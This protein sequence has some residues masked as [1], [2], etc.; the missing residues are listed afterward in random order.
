MNRAISE[1]R[2]RLSRMLAAGSSDRM[3]IEDLYLATL[4]RQPSRE[5]SRGALAYVEQAKDRRAAL[6]DVL[7]GLLNAKEFLLRQ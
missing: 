1:P 3:L 4:S 2:N 5:E 7:W 6:E